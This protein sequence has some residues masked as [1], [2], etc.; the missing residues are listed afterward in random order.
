MLF[1]NEG[2]QVSLSHTLLLEKENKKENM[3]NAI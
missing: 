1:E 2:N 3:K